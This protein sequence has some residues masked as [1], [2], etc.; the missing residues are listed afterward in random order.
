MR[1]ICT[2]R[3]R[4]WLQSSKSKLTWIRVIVLNIPWLY[5]SPLS[6]S[7]VVAA[8]ITRDQR[9][10]GN[11]RSI[12]L[13]S[14]KFNWERRIFVRRS[15]NWNS[16]FFSFSL[17]FFPDISISAR[18]RKSYRNDNENKYICNGL[19]YVDKLDNVPP[20]PDQTFD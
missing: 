20:R 12:R 14:R 10:I 11:E 16:L 1:H 3:Y 18:A 9:E 8:S 7:T 6:A 19:Y 2:Y 15:D 13:D 4:K 5:Y 17:F